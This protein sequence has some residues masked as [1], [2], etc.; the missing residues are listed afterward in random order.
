VR[1]IVAGV[2]GDIAAAPAVEVEEIGGRND[3]V[4]AGG[5]E[6]NFNYGGDGGSWCAPYKTWQRIYD[7]DFLTNLTASAVTRPDK[8]TQSSSARP[9][10][11]GDGHI[12]DLLRPQRSLGGATPTAE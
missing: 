1:V 11:A 4:V 7:Y 8:L 2:V 12:V 6:F 5:G 9:E 3:N 10:H